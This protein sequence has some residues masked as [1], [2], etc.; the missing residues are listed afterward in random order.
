MHHS[1]T[2]VRDWFRAVLFVSALFTS[3]LISA[4]TD[5]GW[6]FGTSTAQPTPSTVLP[7]DVA[8]SEIARANNSG[9]TVLLTT[10]SAS[11]GYP[12]ATGQFNAGAAAR[13]GALN[14]AADA[15]AFFEFSL[16]PEVGKQLV[17]T[18]LGFGTR[19]TG[20]GPQAYAIFTSVDGFANAI[21]VGVLSNNSVWT[22]QN[23][24]IPELVGTSGS[25]V[26]FRIYGYG[27]AGSPSSGTANWRIDDLSVTVF[28]IAASGTPPAV[29]TTDPVAGASGVGLAN[30][31]TVA[32]NQPVTVSNDTFAINGSISGVHTLEVSGGPITYIL[33]PSPAFVPGE[34]ITVTVFGDEVI[35]QSTGALTMPDDYVFTF[36]AV[37]AP[38]IRAIHEVQGTGGAS[39][40]AGQTVTLSG[41]VTASFQS[42]TAGLGGFYLQ[43]K[44]ADY[45]SDPTSS[46]AIF[47]FDNASSNTVPVSPGDVISVAGTVAEFGTGPATLTELVSV[48][49]VTRAG[50]TA[51][52][53]EPIAV[54]LPLSDTDALERLEGMRVRFSQTL[55]ITDNFNLGHFGEFIVS[56]GR[57]FQPTNIVAPGEAANA[58]T[59]ANQLNQLRVNDHVSR[60][61]PDPTPFLYNSA[62]QGD[63]LRGGDTITGLTGVL[64]FG[65]GSYLLEPTAPATVV[66]ANPRTPQAPTRAGRLRV[67]IANV[68]NFFNGNGESGGFPTSRGA[69]TPAEYLR[70]REKI[71]QGLLRLNADIIGLTEVENDGFGPGSAI[72]DL[73][74]TLNAAAPAGTRYAAVDASSADTGSDQIQVAFIYRVETAALVGN[75]ATLNN[76]YF[77]GIARP[78]LAQT[79]REVASGEILTVCV[80]HFR[81]KASVASGAATD[82]LT[83]NP[84]LDQR[85][86]QGN[87]NY[88]RTRE[89][90]TLAAW[91]A[92]D[93]TAS[94]DPDFL[95]VGD[96]NAYAKED[97]VAALESGG[98]INLTAKFEGLNGYSYL[99]GGQYGHLDHALATSALESQVVSAATWHVNADEPVYL[100]Y[101][102]ENK[103]PAQQ[104]VNVATPY[105][106]SD[107]DPVV[108]DLNLRS[109]PPSVTFNTWIKRWSLPSDQ[110][111]PVSDPD[112]D[113]AANLLEYKT[114]TRPDLADTSALPALKTENGRAVFRYT[115]SRLATDGQLALW[116]STDLKTWEPLTALPVLES[117]SGDNDTFRV[118][119]S[120]STRRLFVKLTATL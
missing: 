7:A 26:T 97:P 1:Y 3:S 68:L 48:T 62:G 36:T 120:L 20:T 23:P 115:T 56:S 2:S 94:S 70:Q 101:N 51:P 34:T 21:A 82:G 65:F 28:T 25:P 27:G 72:R 117:S 42:T 88:V 83:P 41:V 47:I 44:E 105:R 19:S 24:V 54:T 85:D 109:L 22:R 10:T 74:D 104:A 81:A 110:Q 55:T 63:T 112:G 49:S 12:G 11:S 17:T 9:S 87:N 46:E 96:L 52:L 73:V 78:P 45:D 16:T 69:D 102:L 32:F 103:S 64:S 53:P 108:V 18:G 31:I 95:I 61:Y 29:N 33:T 8:A 59:A 71:V 113:G 79:F 116:R 92:T 118:E 93:P 99:F 66:A 39:P 38:P 67:A 30:P 100:D 76:P 58:Q 37:T 6:N 43:A 106:Y 60:T 4:Q 107:H 114:G 35:D 90:Q 98:F 91:L 75:P 80:N 84:N 40:F 111:S 77:N 14:T 89:A 13:I 5:I 57:L 15:S 50:A 86:G 119:L